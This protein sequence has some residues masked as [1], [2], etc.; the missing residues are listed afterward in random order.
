MKYYFRVKKA[1]AKVTILCL[2]LLP[3]NRKIFNVQTQERKHINNK[4]QM[5][6]CKAFVL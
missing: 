3:A 5:F 6:L 1:I 2:R 4:G